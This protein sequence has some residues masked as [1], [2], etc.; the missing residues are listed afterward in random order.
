MISRRSNIICQIASILLSLIAITIITYITVTY[1]VVRK[2]EEKLS[3][4][5]VGENIISLYNVVGIRK[6]ESI[7]NKYNKNIIITYK[8]V[9]S[10]D[11]DNYVNSLLAEKYKV[12]TT[13]DL[14][15][16]LEKKINNNKIVVQINKIDDLYTI[17]YY[18]K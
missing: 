6:I 15:K 11:I 5:I 7:D 10:D 16:I 17:I 13:T 9:T 12:V 8:Y 4:T 2:Y 18:I 3:I 1:I 14:N